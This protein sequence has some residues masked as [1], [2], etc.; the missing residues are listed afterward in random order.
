MTSKKMGRPRLDTVPVLIRMPQEM[1][2]F[3]DEYRRAE[4]DI[5]TR[6]EAARRLLALAMASGSSAVKKPGTD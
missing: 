2:D 6:P 5:P 1:L 3:L 4:P